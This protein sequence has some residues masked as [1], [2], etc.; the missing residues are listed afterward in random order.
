MYVLYEQ[1][2]DKISY[3]TFKKCYKHQTYKNLN[4][5]V[6]EYPNN[7]VVGLYHGDIVGGKYYNGMVMENGLSK[8]AFN[9]CN[10]VMMGHIHKRQEL[11]NYDTQL[12]YCGSLIQQNHGETV[13][14]HGFVKWNIERSRVGRYG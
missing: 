2:S 11:K 4:P 6:E 12:V 9:G 14:Q 3:E 1:F 10:C 13:T 7:T 8:E 5:T